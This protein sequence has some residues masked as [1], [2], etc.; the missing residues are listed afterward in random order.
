MQADGP[1]ARAW[2]PGSFEAEIVQDLSN[3][4][5]SF[6]G[7]FFF[8]SLSVS[9]VAFSFPE[10]AGKCFLRVEIWNGIVFPSN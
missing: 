3:H 8:F 7:F 1:R 5:F 10:E 4:M 9:V 6:H 2:D